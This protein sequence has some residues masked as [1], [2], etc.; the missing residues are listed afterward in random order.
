MKSKN[1]PNGK[2]GADDVIVDFC[3]AGQ[4]DGLNI[5]K[6]IAGPVT[7]IVDK[8]DC[9]FLYAGNHVGFSRH[10][11]PFHVDAEGRTYWSREHIDLFANPD[12]RLEDMAKAR[13]KATYV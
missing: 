7:E 6:R 11:K 12:S 4:E 8:P 3:W 5:T 1:F 2:V 13:S 10:F 9:E